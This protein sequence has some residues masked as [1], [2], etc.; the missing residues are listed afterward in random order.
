[1]EYTS[2]NWRGELREDDNVRRIYSGFEAIADVFGTNGE[3][4][5]N[6]HLIAS[7]PALYEALKKLVVHFKLSPHLQAV[8]DGYDEDYIE[9]GLKALTKAEGK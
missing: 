3:D 1:M 7:A 2:G 4:E 8:R 6:A 9:K 5:A